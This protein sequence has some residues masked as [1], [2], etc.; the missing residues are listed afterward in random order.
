MACESA[1][2][3]LGECVVEIDSSGISKYAGGHSTGIIIMDQRIKSAFA[4]FRHNRRQVL[5][6]RGLWPDEYISLAD[7]PDIIADPALLSGIEV[8]PEEL[9]AASDLGRIRESWRAAAVERWALKALA[10]AMTGHEINSKLGQLSGIIADAH[11]RDPE[12]LRL[13]HAK[14]V[15]AEF[16]RNMH[17]ANRLIDEKNSEYKRPAECLSVVNKDYGRLIASGGLSIEMTDAFVESD[18]VFRR[19]LMESVLRNLVQ[20]G[21]YWGGRHS[22]KA[23]IRFDIE[24]R[25]WI[26][27][28]GETQTEAVIRVEDNGPGVKSHMR[29]K[30]FEAGISGRNSTG[31][32]LHLCKANLEQSYLTIQ[33]DE[34][35]SELGGAVFLIGSKNV[36]EPVLTTK[37]DVDMATVA[38]ESLAGMLEDGHFAELE[39]YIEIFE[40]A[41]GR[42]MRLRL[43][44]LETENEKRLAIAV[45]KIHDQLRTYEPPVPAMKV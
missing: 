38:M 16:G 10:T 13:V 23:I 42:V 11:A 25:T 35:S 26:D 39:K 15:V 5:Q 7:V 20:N 29:Q 24:K 31:I 37:A 2:C 12:N 28:E 36:L 4:T 8:A 3:V 14:E 30:V 40:D 21:L 32:G 41:C 18:V 9:V 1:V 27:S 17:F 43:R 19:N 22:K 34:V 44:G 6:D 45:D 33:V